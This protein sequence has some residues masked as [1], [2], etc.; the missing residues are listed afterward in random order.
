MEKEEETDEVN[1][2]KQVSNICIEEE[3]EEQKKLIYFN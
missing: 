1:A 3:Q 2:K